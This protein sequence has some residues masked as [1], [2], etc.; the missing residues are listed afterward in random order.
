MMFTIY[1]GNRAMQKFSAT[2]YILRIFVIIVWGG[3]LMYTRDYKIG[4]QIGGNEDLVSLYF[5]IFLTVREMLLI[6]TLLTRQLF[7]RRLDDYNKTL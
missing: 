6:P 2:C 7:R 1:F 5:T 3:Y 4:Q